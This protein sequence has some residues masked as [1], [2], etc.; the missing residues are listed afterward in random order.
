MDNNTRVQ[1]AETPTAETNGGLIGTDFQK[2]G[3]FYS[4]K[5]THFY[6]DSY[7]CLKTCIY[8]TDCRRRR[9]NS[10]WN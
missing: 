6:V 4:K 8:I 5:T 9:A 2:L 1:E 7:F 3:E 10:T